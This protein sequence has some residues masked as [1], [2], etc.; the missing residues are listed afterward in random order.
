MVDGKY[1]ILLVDDSGPILRSMKEMLQEDYDVKI[2][3]SG[4]LA[5]KMIPKTKPDVI[6]LDYEMPDMN[7]AKTF[8]AIRELPEGKEIPIVFL[9]G[10]DDKSIIDELMKKEPAGYLIKPAAKPKLY[11]IVKKALEEIISH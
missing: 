2:A 6:L 9:S 4:M 10:L 5:L 8:D 11:A 7:G 3:V 1:T